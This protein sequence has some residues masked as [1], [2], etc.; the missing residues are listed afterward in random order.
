[1]TE[2]VLKL[3]VSDPPTFVRLMPVIQAGVEKHVVYV[4]LLWNRTALK[5]SRV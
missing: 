3:K 4:T 1:M 5:V 2:D